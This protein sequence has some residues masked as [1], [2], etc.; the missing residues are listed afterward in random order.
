MSNWQEW[1][2]GLLLLLCAVRIGQNVYTFFRRAK[3]KN[4]PC[5][6]CATGCEL[7]QLYDKKRAEC[8]GTR[9]ETKKN[10]CG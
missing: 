4:N 6:N 2:V 10:C 8:S 9:K 5:A 3:D 1:V 7:K